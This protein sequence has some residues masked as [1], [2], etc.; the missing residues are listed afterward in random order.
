MGI[1]AARVVNM[2]SGTPP[3]PPPAP[4]RPIR[5]RSPHGWTT[6][7][8]R[9]SPDLIQLSHAID[10]AFEAVERHSSF[11]DQTPKP[12]CSGEPRLVRRPRIPVRPI[13][14]SLEQKT[15]KPTAVLTTGSRVED[16][17]APSRTPSSNLILC[18]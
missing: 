5:T 14:D 11:G 1:G 16:D 3:Q 17:I 2:A 6:T 9:A 4:R 18:L 13:L 10:V 8:S 12:G 7:R 15:V